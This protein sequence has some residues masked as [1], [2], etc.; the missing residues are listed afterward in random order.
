MLKKPLHDRNIWKTFFI[1]EKL[2]KR[3]REEVRCRKILV[4]GLFSKKPE[5]FVLYRKNVL[6]NINVRGV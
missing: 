5:I 4:F 6:E 2:E 1:N 3:E